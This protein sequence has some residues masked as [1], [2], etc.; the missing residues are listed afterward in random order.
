MSSLFGFLIVFLLQIFFIQDLKFLIPL[1]IAQGSLSIFPFLPLYRSSSQS[2]YFFGGALLLLLIFVVVAIVRG[3]GELNNSL[4]VKFFSVAHK[5]VPR[6]FVGI[7]I[8]ATVISYFY[9]F[10]LDRLNQQKG[11]KVFDRVLQSSESLAQIWFPGITFDMKMDKA[12]THISKVRIDRSKIDYLQKGIVFSE[13]PEKVQ[14]KIL[15]KISSRI[16][17]TITGLTG[18]PIQP[19]QTLGDYLFESLITKLNSLSNV[20]VFGLEIGTLFLIFFGLKALRI[21][22]YLPAEII[23][24]LVFKILILS[25]FASFGLEQVTK[26]KIV[27]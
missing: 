6:L 17:K 4:R 1:G 2:L 16:K 24:F 12:I 19:S 9:L 25:N 13:L 21:V 8:F 14:Q 15:R 18:V 7:L 27:I 5:V 22:V 3:R 11:R 26:E 20:L 10:H 23:A